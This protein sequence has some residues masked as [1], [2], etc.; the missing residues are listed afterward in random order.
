MPLVASL[1]GC[2]SGES[3]ESESDEE[4]EEEL[5]EAESDDESES[6]SLSEELDELED[7]DEAELTLVLR[8]FV[9]R[10]FGTAVSPFVTGRLVGHT[11]GLSST[12]ESE[13]EEGEDWRAGDWG[14]GM[15]EA[16]ERSRAAWAG[17]WGWSEA[18]LMLQESE[19]ALYRSL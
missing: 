15:R 3:E 13:E 5:D 7:E 17:R 2:E 1:C 19:S 14:R 8:R 6:L 16:E 11:S 4:S 9:G 18:S 12:L 10:P